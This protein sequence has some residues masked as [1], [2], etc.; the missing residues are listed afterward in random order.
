MKYSSNYP[1]L[2]R[3]TLL[4]SGAFLM[5]VPGSTLLAA[6]AAADPAAMVEMRVDQQRE[7]QGVV[8]DANTSDVIIGAS[9]RLKSNP[10]KGTIT[11]IEGRFRFTASP[12]DV[13][14]ITYIG[15][16][17]KEVKLG[18]VS[19]LT[20]EM[21]EDAQALG[22]VVVTA[23]GV[24]QKKESLVGAVT[25]IKSEELRIPTAN[26]S[27]S[28]AG[29]L[30]GVTAYQSS[31]EPGNDGS[32]FYIRGIS[33]F[34]ATSPLIII[35]G[36]EASQGD[37]NAL[38][39]E[40]IESFSILKDATATAMYGTRG[41][42]GV[43]I[44]KT[45]G[46][47]SLERA[48]ITTR[49]E[50]YFAMPNR[51]PKYTDGATYMEMYNEAATN[52]GAG[53]SLY[54]RDKI[55]GTRLGLDPYL[56][57]NVDW[58]DEIFKDISF[59][60]RVNFNVRGGSERVDYFINANVNHET[61]MIR[62]RSSEFFSY[63]NNI[64]IM[65]YTMQTNIN[66]H[67]TKTATVS[68]NLGVELR[69]E[70][71]PATSGNINYLFSSV[72]ANNPVDFAPFYPIDSN[73][74]RYGVHSEYVKW[75]GFNGG[76]VAGGNNPLA[77]LSK[78]YRDTFEST[79]RANVKY[80]Q[81]L[82]FITEGLSLNALISFKNWSST[83]NRRER[84]YNRYY[85]ME[86]GEEGYLINVVGNEQEANSTLSSYGSS[87][88][89]RS[90]YFQAYLNYDRT[91][92]DTHHVSVMALYNQDQY[93]INNVGNN[94]L[95]GSLPQRS[96]GIAARLAYD[97]K[98][99]YLAEINMGY[100]A[101][102]N[103][104]EGHRWGFFPSI[105]LGWNISEEDW[106]ANLKRTVH[107]LKIRGSYGLVGNADS[108]TRF[109][110][111]EQVDLDGQGGFYSGDGSVSYNPGNGP[112]FQRFRNDDISWEV[113]HKLDVGLDIGLFNALNLSLDYFHEER[114]DI[115]QQNNTIPNY[116][117]VANA[118]V[119]GNYGRVRNWGLEISADYGKQITR[120]FSMQFKGTF[121]FTR[122]KILEYAQGFDPRYP[123]L[124][125]IGQSV[126]GI[127]GYVYAGHL[128]MDENEVENSPQQVI[129]GVTEAGDIKYLDIPDIDGN[130]DNRINSNDRV[131]MGHPTVPEIIY[132]FGPSFKYKNWDFS[133]FFQGA[134]NVSMM[135]SGF[136][137]F[138]NYTNRN[139][140]QFIADDYWSVDNQNIYA[141]YPRLTQLPNDNNT[142]ASSYWLRN[143]AYL[144]LKNAEVGYSWKFLRAYVSGANLLT[145][146]PFKEWDPEQGGAGM[147][148][149][150]IQRTV[151]VGVQMN[152]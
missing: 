28:F 72:M 131:F 36:V 104:A 130:T 90:I 78:G 137:P 139:V 76:N 39:P 54:S 100:N 47:E 97:Y 25:Q 115:F 63:K 6:S 95:V 148:S 98:A 27:N 80:N 152:F 113:G 118:E 50:G 143:A 105:A 110:Y 73:V 122:N 5:A 44:V 34:T 9:I 17:T 71:G 123:N 45:K 140:M 89:D 108:G 101:S 1:R 129:G 10:D 66:A 92:N 8:I 38:D 18:N 26:L 126:S 149:Y 82:D 32:T 86:Q 119:W 93:D 150:P 107:N 75:G 70:H 19:L 135:I 20:I 60:Q 114:E 31:G 15:Y 16:K 106:F 67:L 111:L 43:M 29:R 128:F 120:D 37:L 109:L 87:S 59:N 24:G 102:E 49:I 12:G 136:H 64:N 88:G 62:G 74:G 65:R 4:L 141:R 99:K 145:F 77:E 132:G 79:V 23:F 30:T 42:N 46:G 103:F 52:Y 134:A 14:E 35:D 56:Y 125:R 68:M 147:N 40:V 33:T 96:Q 142:V 124:S 48:A 117:G 144:K 112:A 7:Y 83:W 84:S 21:S 61:G 81:K 69:D 85:M 151:N 53:G 3:R 11:D 13:L 133:F 91:F 138:G 22:E 58:Y 55:E 57:P 116:M 127:S 41:A 51:L 2:M 94:N 121:S 146:S